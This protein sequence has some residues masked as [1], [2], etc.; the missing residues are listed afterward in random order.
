MLP[1]SSERLVRGLFCIQQQGTR[2]GQ[3]L[4]IR[5]YSIVTPQSGLNQSQWCYSGESHIWQMD[6]YSFPLFLSS[7]LRHSF[8]HTPSIFSPFLVFFFLSL[9]PYLCL[10][11]F[12]PFSLIPFLQLS[13]QCCV[14]FCWQR[15]E[16]WHPVWGQLF[17]L[18]TAGAWGGS[19]TAK[20]S[21]WTRDWAERM[22]NSCAGRKR[23]KVRGDT[24]KT[25]PKLQ[26]F[27]TVQTE[28]AAQ[29]RLQIY[30]DIFQCIVMKVDRSEQT[31][32]QTWNDGKCINLC[33]F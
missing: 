19:D 9:L 29:K 12:L 18:F 30:M 33:C 20:F 13:P 14:V 24:L 2:N 16:L 31:I 23:R 7:I 28:N 1:Q 10:S 26:E 21:Y 4:Q 17:G 5:Y 22:T 25:H 15:K 27:T 3:F 32:M 8:S 11:L 6:L